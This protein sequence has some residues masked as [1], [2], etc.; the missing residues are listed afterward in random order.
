MYIIFVVDYNLLVYSIDVSD[1][2]L[3]NYINSQMSSHQSD[4]I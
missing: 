2:E 4:N 1:N 3:S